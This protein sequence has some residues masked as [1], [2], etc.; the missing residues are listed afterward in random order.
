MSAPA[1]RP[2]RALAAAAMLLAAAL[3]S[4]SLAFRLGQDQ[5]IFAYLGAEWLEGRWPYLATWD[6]NLPGMAALHALVI[7]ALGKSVFAF[8]LFDFAWQLANAWLVHRISRRLGGRA[9]ALLAPALFV[10]IYQGY[11]PWNTAQREGFAVLFVLA[12]FQ[13]CLTRERRPPAL[14][15]AAIGL[16]FGLAMLVKPTMLALALFYLPLARRESWP[17]RA[18]LLAIAAAAASAPIAATILAFWARGGLDELYAA[19][20][21]YQRIYVALSRPEGPLFAAAL[22][23]LAGLGRNAAVLALVYPVF[24]LLFRSP[25]RRERWML[26]LGYLGSVVAVAVQGTYAGYHYLPG[27]ALGAILVGT[28]FQRGAELARLGGRSALALAVLAIAAATPLY[29]RAQ[30]VRDLVSGHFLAPP[31]A[32][33]LRNGT[34]FDFTESWELARHLRERT[35]PGERIQVWGHESLVYYLAERDAASRFQ[36]SSPLVVRA[37]GEPLSPLQRR[38]RAEF[39]AELARRAPSYVTVTTGD[40]WWWAP[41]RQTSEQLL[42]DFPEWKR[43]VAAGYRLETRIGRFLVYRR[44]APAAG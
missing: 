41:G 15:A 17:R 31:R 28:L 21:A 42:D 14:T 5:G 23:R 40:D 30:N 22:A 1:E 16:G 2:E 26:Y 20:F 12:G 29:V 9:A 6:Q 10:L 38:W 25:D 4:P 19:C 8:R 18:R 44:E 36:V 13:L 35:A 34:V 27:L 7:A 3:L 39:L 32:D 33:E 43:F 24:L 37:P 11:G